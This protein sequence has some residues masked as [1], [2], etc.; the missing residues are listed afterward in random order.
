M[1]TFQTTITIE[2]PLDLSIRYQLVRYTHRLFVSWENNLKWTR[3]EL[4]SYLLIHFIAIKTIDII[5]RIF[6]PLQ[7]LSRCNKTVHI[8]KPYAQDETRQRLTGEKKPYQLKHF[9]S[10]RSFPAGKRLQPT[11]LTRW[12]KRPMRCNG[13]FLI[14]YWGEVSYQSCRCKEWHVYAN[15]INNNLR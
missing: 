13:L 7:G 3:E 10:R 4:F 8:L 14:G 11:T 6:A 15:P 2:R 1:K 5:T 9:L 12:R